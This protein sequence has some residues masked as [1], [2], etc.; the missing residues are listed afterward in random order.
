[1]KNTKKSSLSIIMI[2]TLLVQLISGTMLVSADNNDY[3][4]EVRWDFIDGKDG[5]SLFKESATDSATLAHEDDALKINAQSVTKGKAVGFG[6][7]DIFTLDTDIHKYLVIKADL[8]ANITKISAYLYQNGALAYSWENNENAL[9]AGI[10]EGENLYA[11]KLDASR[12]SGTT[13]AVADGTYSKVEVRF[14]CGKTSDASAFPSDEVLSIDYVAFSSYNKGVVLTGS[15]TTEFTTGTEEKPSII[16]GINVNDETIT[17]PTETEGYSITELYSLTYE[18]LDEHLNN[19]YVSYA[20]GYSDPSISY[21]ITDKTEYKLLDITAKGIKDLVEYTRSYRI[22]V[23]PIPDPAP[24]I[25]I[26]ECTYNNKTLTFSGYV[27]NGRGDDYIRNEDV[28]IM[29]Y[30]K[31]NGMGNNGQNLNVWKMLTTDENGEFSGSVMIRDYEVANQLYTLEVAFCSS[32]SVTY[33]DVTYYNDTCV[34]ALVADMATK[35]DGVFAY[36]TSGSNKVI[37]E[38]MGVSFDKYES[39]NA[40]EKTAINNNTKIN[41][42]D[43]TMENVVE[44]ANG[45]LLAY[46]AKNVANDTALISILDDYDENVMEITINGDDVSSFSELTPYSRK[47][48]VIS[49]FKSNVKT[50]DYDDWFEFKNGIQE[51][52]LLEYISTQRSSATVK[53]IILDNND[54]ILYGKTTADVDIIT[55]LENEKNVSP[56]DATTYILNQQAGAVFADTNV[57][58]SAIDTALDKTG[59]TNSKDDSNSSNTIKDSFVVSGGG[60]GGGSS[61]AKD[62]VEEK[63]EEKVEEKPEDSF[64]N[65]LYLDLKNYEWAEA[66]INYLSEL[67]VVSGVGNG[68]FEPSRD[69]TREEFTKLLCEAFKLSDGDREINFTDVPK[70]AWYKNY[71]SC[72]VANGIVNGISDDLFGS[73]NKITRE[74]MAVMIFR[75]L[76]CVGKDMNSGAINF[77]DYNEIADYAQEAVAL[78]AGTGIVNGVGNSNFAPKSAASRAEAAVIIYRCIELLEQ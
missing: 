54:I 11:L 28:L 4:G 5:A 12:K 21:K 29:A 19:M 27:M 64:G 40:S 37:F 24:T 42:S 60:G 8:P 10:A 48:T 49:H 72:A 52:M 6:L 44:I 15:S 43:V 18:E 67:G 62:K 13:N 73:G 17:L 14:R 59:N 41:Q 34:N 31:E 35:T 61:S 46:E 66:S 7:T 39:H 68:L 32:G 53:E 20:D 3:T 33:E 9:F 77:N 45:T 56:D 65:N 78:L 71:V 25:T 58:L 16:D 74:D 69:V 55:A 1:M 47:K 38:S 30:N 23:V 75:A 63:P 26:N 22:K 36:M 76:K 70:D 2:L 50:A 57:L 51:S